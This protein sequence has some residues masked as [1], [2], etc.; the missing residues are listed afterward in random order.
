MQPAITLNSPVHIHFRFVY[1]I[2]KSPQNTPIISHAPERVDNFKK[3]SATINALFFQILLGKL[4]YYLKNLYNW[5]NIEE[6]IV[7]YGHDQSITCNHCVNLQM[8]STKCPNIQQHA[9]I[10]DDV[11]GPADMNTNHMPNGFLPF[12]KTPPPSGRWLV[13]NIVSLLSQ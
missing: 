12:P 1:K 10:C 8:F 5:T 9:I 6:R 13:L 2:N 7:E 11:N 4:Y 3:R